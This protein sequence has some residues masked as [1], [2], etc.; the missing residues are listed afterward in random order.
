MIAI[1]PSRPSV[2]DGAARPAFR[3]DHQLGA[4]AEGP[5]VRCR[6]AASIMSRGAEFTGE[7]PKA[8]RA[9]FRHEKRH[10]AQPRACRSR[11]GPALA[12]QP[13]AQLLSTGLIATCWGYRD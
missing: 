7:L 1:F 8:L 5:P 11:R 10:F 13:L 6:W 2:A 12:H 9:V 4:G 3:I